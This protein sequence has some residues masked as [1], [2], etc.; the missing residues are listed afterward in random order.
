LNSDQWDGYQ[1]DQADLIAHLAAQP[2]AHGD[3]VVLTGDIHSSWAADLPDR[4]TPDYT[5]AGVEFVCPSVTSDGF[6]ELVRASVPAGTPTAAVLGATAGVVGAVTATNPW[7][8]YLDGVG[9][10]FTLIDVTPERVQADY[11]HT[12]VPTDVAPDPRVDPTVEPAYTR[13]FQTLAGSRR[14]TPAAGPVGPRADEPA[15]HH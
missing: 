14:V 2:P 1:A 9:H 15:Q 13:S 12:P 6:Y 7:V 4:R 10:G 5:S 8:R 3:A 11:F